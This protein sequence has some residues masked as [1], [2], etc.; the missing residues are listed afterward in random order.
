ME[1]AIS[2]WELW[3]AQYQE[4]RGTPYQPPVLQRPLVYLGSMPE[5]MR[6]HYFRSL[7][8]PSQ[9]LADSP[10]GKGFRPE[11]WALPEGVWCTEE[12]TPLQ[13]KIH[14]LLARSMQRGE[15]AQVVSA[16]RML[17][18]RMPD[19]HAPLHLLSLVAPWFSHANGITEDP[20]N[21]AAS[22][23]VR[24]LDALVQ[25]KVLVPLLSSPAKLPTPPA[26]REKISQKMNNTEENFSQASGSS[27]AFHGAAFMQPYHLEH[28][29]PWAGHIPFAAWIIA[30]Q[31]P[32]VFVELG[33]F[34]GISYL[35]FCQSISE[36]KTGTK[37]WAVDTWQGDI[38]TGAYDDSTYNGLR[39]AHDPYYVGFSTLLRMMFDEARQYFSDGSIDLLHIDGLHTYEG[40]KNDFDT[41]LP[42]M[43]RRGVIIFHDTNVYHPDF[44]VH[45]LWAEVSSHYPSLHFPHSNG[46]GVLLVGPEQ[47]AELLA[48]CNAQ[49]SAAQDNART[50]FGTLGARLEMR[51]EVMVKDLQLKDMQHRIEHLEHSGQRRHEWI[52]K[53]DAD[54]LT[55]DREKAAHREAQRMLQAVYASRSWRATALLRA[56]GDFARG[57]GGRRLLSLARRARNAGRYIVRGE[58]GALQKRVV[59]L[60]SAGAR[61]KRLKLQGTLGSNMGILA[62]SHTLFIAHALAHALQKAGFSVTVMDAVPA[63]GFGLDWYIVICPQMF[64]QL[65]PGEKRT[66]EASKNSCFRQGLRVF[67]FRSMTGIFIFGMLA[68]LGFLIMFVDLEV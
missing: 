35:S 15:Y 23:L 48:I 27:M 59:E 53:L 49:R 13:R 37:A 61:E 20:A 36:N 65:P 45:R 54:L 6:L 18:Q 38:H 10:L 51:V 8:Y 55:A 47:P 5:N 46:L 31:R 33:T 4:I 60:R 42:K 58:W 9:P 52:Q 56:A 67:I 11:L 3:S 66:G 29:A 19:W 34:T 1:K 28:P 14:E 30:V 39:K 12:L 68:S 64:K 32:D 40:V 16:C 57:K 25:G 63:E 22:A 26:M 41:W 17:R 2:D 44:G 21:E 50:F 7:A 62:T 24:E 43:S